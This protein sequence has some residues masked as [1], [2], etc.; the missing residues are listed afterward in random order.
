[1]AVNIMDRFFSVKQKRKQSV[2]KEELHLVG[3]TAILLSSK[4]E[5]VKPIY[6]SQI[7][8]DAGHKKFSKA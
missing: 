6:M 3:L 8:Q 1:M 4:L 2:D 5:D 7:V